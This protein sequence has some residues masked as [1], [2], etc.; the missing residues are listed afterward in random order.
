M[1][2]ERAQGRQ[3]EDVAA[4]QLGYDI[5]SLTP[6]SSPTAAGEGR[7]VRREG[8]IRYIEVKGRA[9]SGAVALT[10]NEWLMAQ[11]LGADYWLYVV[12]NCSTK[13]CL[14]TIPNPAATLH[15]VEV[16]EVVRY[17]IEDWKEAAQL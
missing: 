6:D 1:A 5:R 4:Q 12:E 11:R 2:Y 9:R 3:P 10:T 8:A 16:R 17:V 7:T 13:P 14:Y 15:P